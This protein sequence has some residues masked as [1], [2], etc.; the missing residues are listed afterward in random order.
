MDLG[1]FEGENFDCYAIFKF[2]GLVQFLSLKKM[3]YPNLVRMFYPNLEI[4][5]NFLISEVKK[6]RISVDA[7][8]FFHLTRLTSEGDS[9]VGIV[10]DEWK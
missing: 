5:C 4:S 6:I 9:C 1:F 7:G 10:P 3:I 2:V 8:L